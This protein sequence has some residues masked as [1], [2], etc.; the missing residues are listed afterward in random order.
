MYV[1]IHTYVFVS[2][3]TCTYMYIYM[4]MC[5]YMYIYVYVE[6]EREPEDKCTYICTCSVGTQRYLHGLFA[7]F[8]EMFPLV[9]VCVRVHM[10]I[11]VIY[12]VAIYYTL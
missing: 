2:V 4:Y 12:Y 8:P 1:Y 10:Y 11:C 7:C 9:C 5:M 3:D 6:R